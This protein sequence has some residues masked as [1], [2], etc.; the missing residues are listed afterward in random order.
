[1][2]KRLVRTIAIVALATVVLAVA[3]PVSAANTHSLDLERGSTQ[4]ASIVDASQTGLDFST[5]FTA[6]AWV[7]PETIGANNPFI[8]K[9][10]YNTQLEY[11][12]W[13]TAANLFCLDVSDNGVQSNGHWQRYC[14]NSAVVSDTTTWHHLAVSF[15]I[16]GG[17]PI[18]TFYVD[19]SSVASALTNG[20]TIGTSL[21]NSDQPFRVGADPDWLG[22]YYDGLIDEVRMWSDVRTSGEISANYQT[23]LVGNEAGLVGYWK[24]NNSYLD[25]T[26]NNNDLTAAGSPVFST[27]IPIWPAAAVDV[28]TGRRKQ[29]IIF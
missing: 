13:L 3:L 25:E 28:P 2:I 4:Q 8:A 14:S 19:G 9:A 17:N 27:D 7:K 1:M 22:A 11:V 29:A 5:T 10:L 20:T 24:F 21:H 16:N 15:D 26:A 6:E 23:E 12:I 18:V